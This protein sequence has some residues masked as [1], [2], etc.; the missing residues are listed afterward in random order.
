MSNTR[1]VP[2][3]SPVP[4]TSPDT[5][6]DT[7]IKTVFPSVKAMRCTQQCQTSLVHKPQYQGTTQ[8]PPGTTQISPKQKNGHDSLNLAQIEL[9]IAEMNTPV[10]PS[11]KRQ[12]HQKPT[13]H[14]KTKKYSLPPPKPQKLH[15]PTPKSQN[16]QVQKDTTRT[17]QSLTM[18]AA[19]MQQHCEWV[20]SQTIH[21]KAHI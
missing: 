13:S 14:T 18:T 6:P 3:T 2:S 11:L 7:R 4:D 5:C 10:Y 19:E 16:P 9:K 20:Q 21:N 17:P 8:F 15:I 1:S 12:K